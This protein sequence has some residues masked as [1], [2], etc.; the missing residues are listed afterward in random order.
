[1][2]EN[3]REIG[4]EEIYRK[5]DQWG[6]ISQNEPHLPPTITSSPLLPNLIEPPWLNSSGIHKVPS[7]TPTKT[8]LSVVDWMRGFRLLW[9]SILVIFCIDT[10]FHFS[11]GWET[12]RGGGARDRILILVFLLLSHLVAR[13]SK[14]V[15]WI[16]TSVSVMWGDSCGV[17]KI[18]WS[19]VLSKQAHRARRN[20]TW[21][22]L[23]MWF[24]FFFFVKTGCLNLFY[25]GV[26]DNFNFFFFFF[27]L[28]VCPHTYTHPVYSH[29]LFGVI[30]ESILNHPEQ[31]L[32]RFL[33][34]YI[35]KTQ[36][37]QKSVVTW[38]H[39]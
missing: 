33:S 7:P 19:L 34:V 32:H 6:R 17:A 2:R 10:S 3:N 12:E 16:P 21:Q 39:L 23:F 5:K 15:R 11:R 1:M 22:A 24:F 27:P 28:E 35:K 14:W 20:A 13:V 25:L 8:V 18:F 38:K 29:S 36:K 31:N 4:G 9:L 30:T 26:F 37:V